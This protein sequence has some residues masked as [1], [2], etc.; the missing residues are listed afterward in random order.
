MGTLLF[1]KSTI[2]SL[3]VNCLLLPQLLAANSPYVPRLTGIV[4]LP[5]QKS[6]VLEFD[7]PGSS[8]P[9]L[10][11]AESQR[12]GAIEVTRITPDTRAVELRVWGTNV[13]LTVPVPDDGRFPRTV[14]GS[15][16]LANADLDPVLDL[17]AGLKG[18]TLLR[19]PRLPATSLSIETAVT[20]QAD[21]ARALE[22]AFA[23]N[24]IATIQDGDKFV[25]VVPDS[26]AAI[27][28]PRSSE[29]KSSSQE[30]AGPE[31]FPPGAM[32]FS[33]AELS[34]MTAIY[35]GLIGRKLDRSQQPQKPTLPINLKNHTPLTK[36]EGIYALETLFS[37]QGVKVVPVGNDSC[38]IVPLSAV[39]R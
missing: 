37:W 35:A 30:G 36:A 20:N 31:L 9:P 13:L 2:L 22:K 6:V 28:K 23:A 1:M 38:K 25:M 3:L 5:H 15:L 34:Q 17:Y 4:N 19:S 21:A 10:I 32:N 8:S 27:V 26:E 11:L 16:A 12:E 29:I 39:R 7:P 14:G 33:H 24:G 18:R